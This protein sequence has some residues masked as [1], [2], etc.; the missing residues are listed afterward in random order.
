MTGNLNWNY[1]NKFNSFIPKSA[2]NLEK[3]DINLSD[4]KRIYNITDKTQ[5]ITIVFFWTNFLRKNSLEAFKVI[6]NNLKSYSMNN[7]I[8]ILT[9]NTDYSF[10]SSD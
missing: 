7:D 4:I 8:T 6:T 1:D 9:I 10:I 5:G 3:T 2:I